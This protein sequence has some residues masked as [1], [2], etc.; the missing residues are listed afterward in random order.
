MAK[1][2]HVLTVEELTVMIWEA[3]MDADECINF[4]EFA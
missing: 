4:Q 1:L 3:V 2:G